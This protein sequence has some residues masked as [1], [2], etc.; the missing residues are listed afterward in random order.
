MILLHSDIK[1]VIFE[2]EEILDS[3]SKLGKLITDDYKDCKNL[4]L[5]ALLKGSVPFVGDLMKKIDLN[6]TVEY[7]DVSSYHGGMESSGEVKILKDLDTPI[8]NKDV[9][10]VE[11]IIDTGKTL[12]TVISLL[13]QRGANSVK[14]VTLIDKPVGRIVDLEADYIGLEVGNE[15]IVGY[16]LD[17]N[18]SYRN[19]DYIGILKEEVYQQEV[20]CEKTKI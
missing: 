7:M 1:K 9:L 6:L 14:V 15:F 2:S 18:E 16:G 5:V 20:E 19:L 13:K 4:I 12:K 17:Y 11:D 3:C 8:T 10:I